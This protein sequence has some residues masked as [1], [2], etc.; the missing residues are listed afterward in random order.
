MA[1]SWKNIT[2]ARTNC[3]ADVLGLAGFLRDD[4]L[5]C[6]DD[7][8][9]RS[10]STA[11]LTREH[12]ENTVGQSGQVES[13]HGSSHLLR[14]ASVTSRCFEYNV[15]VFV[16]HVGS[17]PNQGKGGSGCWPPKT[18]STHSDPLR[19]RRTLWSV[20]RLC[21]HP[22]SHRARWPSPERYSLKDPSSLKNA[23]RPKAVLSRVRD[24]HRMAET[25]GSGRRS[26]VWPEGR[27]PGTSCPQNQ[28]R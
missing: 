27:K 6:H 4:D 12:I 7:P 2:V 11:Q 15:G 23:T 21:L 1:L 24:S 20:M 13:D 17:S 8:L 18:A 9:G 3:C 5:I 16:R 26:R 28:W 10:Y 25:S 14:R 22:P 19:K